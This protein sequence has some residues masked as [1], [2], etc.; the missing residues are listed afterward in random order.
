MA[1]TYH[2]EFL[3]ATILKWQPLL[4]DDHFKKIIL[5]SFEWLVTENKC[6]IHG[7]VIMPNHIHLLWRIHNGWHRPEVQG[8][9][10]SFT[11]HEFQRH[12]K[13]TN[14]A[15]LNKHYVNDADRKYQF[16]ER[17]PMIKECHTDHFLNQKME[18]LHHNPCQAHWQLTKVPADYYWSSAAFYEKKDRI[19][20][21]W[22]KHWEDS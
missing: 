19:T 5:S 1:M 14:P 13:I 11:A 3:T 21:P 2:T 18:Y 15:L 10:F 4:L 22:L 9:L 12:L 6:T 17:N 20:F 7:F 16:W 8:A